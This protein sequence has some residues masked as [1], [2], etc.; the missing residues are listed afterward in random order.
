MDEERE[1]TAPSTRR[2]SLS[3]VTSGLSDDCR[4]EDERQQQR[5]VRELRRWVKAARTVVAATPG[6]ME[7]LTSDWERAAGFYARFGI[8]AE[9]FGKGVS[10]SMMEDAG[11]SPGVI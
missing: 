6:L 5:R 2:L 3:D 9:L 7:T 8:D 10:S 11:D 4:E 1:E